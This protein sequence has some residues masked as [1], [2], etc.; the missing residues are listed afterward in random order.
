[1]RTSVEDE[2]ELAVL[3][4][5]VLRGQDALDEA[6]VRTSDFGFI[7][8]QTVFAAMADLAERG[9]PIDVVTIAA[10]LERRGDLKGCGG[11]EFLN[12]LSDR[13]A[14]ARNVVWH[15]QRLRELAMARRLRQAMDSMISAHPD[16]LL[17]RAREELP[18]LLDGVTSTAARITDVVDQSLDAVARAAMGEAPVAPTGL[19]PIDAML[20][21]GLRPGQL[22]VV[23]ARPSMGK[24]AL[25]TSWAAEAA[26]AGRPAYIAS[27]EMSDVEI[28]L[29]IL[30]RLALVDLA[31]L[32]KGK[33]TPLQERRLG[34]AAKE[35][36][37][38][39]LVVDGDVRTL[40]QLR[41]RVRQWARRQSRPAW[42]AVDYVQLMI[43][44][45]NADNREQEISGISRGLKQ[46]ARDA[47][48]AVVAC[49]QLNRGV[50]T[51]Q[52]K[53]PTNADLRESGALEQDADVILFPFRE[54]QYSPTP[55]NAGRAE[56]NVSKQRNGPT[57]PVQLA[58]AK[59]LAAFFNP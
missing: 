54:E 33:L 31:A 15:G 32:V 22:V 23:G 18:A 9:Q 51:R 46:L 48:V 27:L 5:V 38:A 10:E 35:V 43:Y 11:F 34:D 8:H 19:Q 30:A 40:G 45:G 58:F 6:A 29:R 1:M 2:H 56:L 26:R 52:E 12:A 39:P 20:A 49:S 13:Y 36:K 7:R 41:G 55:Q 44:E 14:T 21:G 42:A 25:V 53:R 28:V 17:G 37:S 24:T 47:G 16:E 4:A 57:G 50:E 3:G 59:H